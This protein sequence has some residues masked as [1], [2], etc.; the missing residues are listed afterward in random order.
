MNCVQTPAGIISLAL[1]FL[2]AC[3]ERPPT[4]TDIRNAYAQ[5]LQHDPVHEI[6]LKAKAP[7]LVIPSQEPNCVPDGTQHFD[8]RI[9]VI[10]ENTEGPRSQEQRIHIRRADS[11]TWIIDSLN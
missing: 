7:P 10:Y 3:A 4:V 11:N 8:C 1:L 9:K 2:G 5:H 6:G